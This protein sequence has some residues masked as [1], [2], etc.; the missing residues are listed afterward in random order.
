QARAAQARP[1]AAKTAAAPAA[2]P[3]P[4]ARKAKLSYKDQR[5][6]DLLPRRIEEI[7]AAIA[8]GEADLADPAL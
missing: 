5:D 7:D 4:P 3:P 8:K 6:Y 2:P 1:A